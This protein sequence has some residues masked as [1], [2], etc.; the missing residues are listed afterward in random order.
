MGLGYRVYRQTDSIGYIKVKNV[1]IAKRTIVHPCLGVSV[2]TDVSD[3][4]IILHN[5]KQARQYLHQQ[6]IF[7]SDGDHNFIHDEI[8]R[9][10]QL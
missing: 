4:P 2:I 1:I 6:P 9:C 5:Q 10:D 3:I 8:M 7:V